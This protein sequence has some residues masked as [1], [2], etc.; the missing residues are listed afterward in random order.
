MTTNEQIAF[1]VVSEVD[2]CKVHKVMTHL[3]WTWGN[4]EVPT[5]GELLKRAFNIACNAMD[6]AIHNDETMTIGT[7]GIKVTATPERLVTVSFVLSEWD[8][9]E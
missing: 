3:N 7:G 9:Y 6:S 5:Q 8:N 2:W 4:E 1:T